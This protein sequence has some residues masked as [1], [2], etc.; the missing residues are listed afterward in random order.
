MPNSLIGAFFLAYIA[1]FSI[2]VMTLLSLS[3]AVGLLIDDSI[4]VRENIFRH[5]ELGESPKAVAVKGTNEVEFAVLSTTLSILAVFI[6][7]SFLRGVV[8][9]FFR[10]FG[11]TVAFA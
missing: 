5:R 6:P 7:I 8:G 3:L 2:N 10:Q 4:V 1:G 11:L 9:Q